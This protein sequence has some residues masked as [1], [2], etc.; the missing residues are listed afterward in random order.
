MSLFEKIGGDRLRE[1]LTDFYDRL[2]SDVM[3]GF[4]FKGKDKARLIQKEWELT[5]RMLGADVEYEG[6]G[7]REVHAPLPIMGGA[8]RAPAEGPR[9]DRQDGREDASKPQRNGN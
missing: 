6:R 1:V 4:M 8:L 5:A 3:I 7:I 2:F 9:G